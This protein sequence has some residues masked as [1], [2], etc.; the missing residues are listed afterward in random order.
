MSSPDVP[1]RRLRAAI[2][3]ALRVA[4][5]GE[6]ADPVS[7][8]PAPL[9]RYLTFARL[10]VPALEVARRVVDDDADFRRRVADGTSADEVGEAGWLWLTRPEGWE[11]RLG[12]VVDA[13][14]QRRQDASAEKE[15]RSALKRIAELEEAL[16]RADAAT[17]TQRQL[18]ADARQEL[19]AERGRRR[20][21]ERRIVELEAAVAEA[22]AE[23][24]AA[25]ELRSRLEAQRDDAVARAAAVAMERPASGPPGAVESP[26]VSPRVDF[27]ALSRAI[28]V[29]S[30][31]L[32]EAREL[33]D[34]ALP[35]GF[36]APTVRKPHPGGD[37]TP[38]APEAHVRRPVKLPGGVLD[39]GV[40]AA[41]HLLRVANVVLLVDGYNISH[42][43]APGQP[44]K[45]QR[46][47][48]LDALGELQA[49]TGAAVE[50][51]FDGGAGQRSM[52]RG[53]PD[54]RSCAL[55][56]ARDRGRRRPRRPGGDVARHEAG[57]AGH[58]RPRAPRPGPAPRRQPHRRP[59]ADGRHAP[60]T[61]G[62]LILDASGTAGR[63]LLRRVGGPP[64]FSTH[65]VP[66]GGT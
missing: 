31:A 11:S 18:A 10:P 29:A 12:E 41:D 36:I 53:R 48:L 49:R 47:R 66:L 62:S 19:D 13:A 44:L 58:E 22:G 17:A 1:T 52:G 59:P 45:E 55:L 57:G 25:R 37:R 61:V 56:A 43:L 24:D 65:L 60:L 26:V 33:V 8:A 28:G 6:E 39:D 51:V 42:A 27:D 5:D 34:G 3:A 23:A 50:V 38:E 63:C 7:P 20:S 32:G 14:E 15:E 35:T 2:E 54:P 16:R 64:A 21:S 40:E 30:A 9:R 4:K 46:A